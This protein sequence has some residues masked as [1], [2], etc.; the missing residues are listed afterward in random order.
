MAPTRTE[1]LAYL[2]RA[3]SSVNANKLNGIRAELDFA[4]YVEGAGFAS[5][6]TPGGWILR[7]NRVASFGK[8]S[9]VA[10]FPLPVAPAGRTAGGIDAG[11]VGTAVRAIAAHLQ[12][13]NIDTY[14][15]EL[16]ASGAWN[17]TL[18]GRPSEAA[19]VPV[20]DVLKGR[21]TART[22]AYNHLRY[23]NDPA[24][25]EGFNDLE[26]ARLYALESVRIT[27]AADY[28]AEASDIDTL[29]WGRSR[30]YPIEMK[31]KTRAND[32]D[33]GPWFGLD[34]GPFTKLGFY[35]AWYQ[36][37]SSLFV[38]REIGDVQTRKLVR[39]WVVDFDTIAK[40]A[41]WVLR[42]G[43]TSM[44][45]SASAVIRIPIDAFTELDAAYLQ[46]LD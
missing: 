24:S 43:G 38:V 3:Y 15:C 10:L 2:A 46:S 19:P 33:I 4:R 31:E 6:T 8:E 1:M 42:S 37:F 29:L 32:Q 23:K 44:G 11:T 21:F 35:A 26:L 34:V 40:R 14:L 9:S 22:R 41:S 7:P 39:W 5:R 12:S 13:A 45:G 17:A 36:R 20:A 25:L 16:D 28:F 30:V 18:V 27:V